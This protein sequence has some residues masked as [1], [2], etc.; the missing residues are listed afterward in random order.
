MS[1]TEQ[2]LKSEH[3]ILK[4]VMIT[5]A[6]YHDQLWKMMASGSVDLSLIATDRAN[7]CTQ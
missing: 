2:I 5:G 7:D 4:R 6:N 1:G 3:I